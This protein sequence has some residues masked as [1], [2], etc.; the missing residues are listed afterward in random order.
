M[1][2]DGIL[3]H[4]NK[5]Q[6]EAKPQVFTSHFS[7]F[8]LVLALP[9]TVNYE[10]ETVNHFIFYNHIKMRFYVYCMLGS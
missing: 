6:S 9:G 5:R 1:N 10:L 7:V 2:S 3:S 8:N 4:S